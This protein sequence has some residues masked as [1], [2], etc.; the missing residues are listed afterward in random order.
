MHQNIGIHP[1]TVRQVDG[2]SEQWN[3]DFNERE[4]GIRFITMKLALNKNVR[5]PS[6]RRL[7]V[8]FLTDGAKVKRMTKA[9]KLL[10]KLRYLVDSRLSPNFSLPNFLYVGRGRERNQQLCLFNTKTKLV[11]KIMEVFE[12]LSRDIVRNS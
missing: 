12:V 5:Y 6:Y 11:A 3:L 1:A 2:K 9:K 10:N 7:K 8:Q 4:T